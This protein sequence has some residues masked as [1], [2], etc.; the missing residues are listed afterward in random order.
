MHTEGRKIDVAGA[1]LHFEESGNPDG[2]EILFLHG[3]AGSLDDWDCLGDTFADCRCV[4][5]DTRGHGASTLGG[6]SLDYPRL[7]DDAE[8]IIRET[9]LIAPIII[10]HSDGGITGIHLA[11]RGTVPIGGLVTI[12]AHGDEFGHRL[13]YSFAARDHGR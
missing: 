8:A 9:A 10:G 6:H 2:P 1:T 12:A 13:N 11:A 7:A 3:G 4:L 5:L